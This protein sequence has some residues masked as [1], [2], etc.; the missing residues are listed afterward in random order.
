MRLAAIEDA[1]DLARVH[2]DT[3]RAAYVGL[4]PEPVIAS[5]FL[6]TSI[7][8]WRTMRPAPPCHCPVAVAV[9]VAVAVDDG[10]TTIGFVR[11][12][13]SR[14]EEVTGSTG[15]VHALY[16]H[17]EHWRTG[18]GR[19]LLGSATEEL[20]SDGFTDATLWVLTHNDR[21]RRFY[22]RCGW[23][24]DGRSRHDQR[25]GAVLDEVRYRRHLAVA[26]CCRRCCS[27]PRSALTRVPGSEWG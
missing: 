12:G 9:A 4:I 1:D 26:S 20:R 2:V 22:E 11:C 24:T 14:D 27:P 23:R 25:E 21:A 10:G 15:E 17:P 6:A 5:M 8:R 7:E 18:A 13:P 3:W 19:E 16:V